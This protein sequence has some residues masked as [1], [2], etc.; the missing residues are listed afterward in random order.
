MMKKQPMKRQQIVVKKKKNPNKRPPKERLRYQLSNCARNYL[1]A[2]TNPFVQINGSDLPCIPDHIVLPSNKVQ[3]TAR[4]TFTVGTSGF[5]FVAADPYVG[6]NNAGEFAGTTSSFPVLYTG[7]TYTFP[8]VDIDVSGDAPAV[9]VF[10]ANTNSPFNAAG[11]LLTSQMRVVGCGLRVRYSGTE[12]YRGGTLALYRSQDNASPPTNPSLAN[13]LQTPLSAMV[14]VTRGW[15]SVCYAPASLDDVSYR[16]FNSAY[17]A[18]ATGISHY[19]LI[20]AVQGPAVHTTQQTFDFEYVAYYEQIGA[21][22][23]L[24]PSHSDPV[25][26]GAIQ[27][28]TAMA[29]LPDKPPEQNEQTFLSKIG[30][31]LANGISGIAD[32]AVSAAGNYAIRSLM[33]TGVQ[34]LESAPPLLLTL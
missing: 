20:I 32:K 33:K 11:P 3:V 5:G 25:G 2:L 22:L 17:N 16:N 6:I 13:L 10:G 34:M 23:Q 7:A 9:G 24:S 31:Y 1:H 15:H 21:S 28:V 26:V 4:G 18:N 12:L 30:Q 19:S 27:A 8:Y 29:R 14:P